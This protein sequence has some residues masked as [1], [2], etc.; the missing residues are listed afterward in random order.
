MFVLPA[1]ALVL[2]A[3]I[4]LNDEGLGAA[5]AAGEADHAIGHGQHRIAD[6]GVE[7]DPLVQRA[8]TAERISMP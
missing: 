1:I 7:I 4:R 2:H 5:L 8:A 3:A 6:V